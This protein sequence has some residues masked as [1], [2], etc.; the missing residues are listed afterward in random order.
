MLRRHLK[1]VEHVADDLLGGHGALRGESREI[2]RRGR[3]T[4]WAREST[5]IQHR[6]RRKEA[7]LTPRQ[8]VHRLALVEEPGGEAHQFRMDHGVDV[9]G[10][11]PLQQLPV[12]RR[13]RLRRRRRQRPPRDAGDHRIPSRAID[14]DWRHT[15]GDRIAKACGV[16]HVDRLDHQRAPRR[17]LGQAERPGRLG[18]AAEEHAHCGI[19]VAWFD[20]RARERRPVLVE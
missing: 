3:G 6:D 14:G 18:V 4:A 2:R 10:R 12:S 19:D 17:R 9:L 5:R 16:A 13:Q 8:D 20:S 15:F 11:Q 7:A 1:R